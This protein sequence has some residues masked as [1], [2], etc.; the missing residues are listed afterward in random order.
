VFLHTNKK[1]C[2]LHANGHM[3][4]LQIGLEKIPSTQFGR[5]ILWIEI[6][7]ILFLKS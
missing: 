5:L 6:L 2:F 1:K 7:C 4:I 3:T